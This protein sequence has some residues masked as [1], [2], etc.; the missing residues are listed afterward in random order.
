MLVEPDLEQ[1]LRV[2]ALLPIRRPDGSIDHDH[3]RRRIRRVRRAQLRAWS[4]T[5][6]IRPMIAVALIA[7][8]VLGMPRN[9]GKS[10]I[11]DGASSGTI[12]S[13]TR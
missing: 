3:Y 13:P 7:M 2:P 6:C 4:L 10:D 1:I 5:P 8:A 11:I 12:V 9:G